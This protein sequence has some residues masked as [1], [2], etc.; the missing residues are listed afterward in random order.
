MPVGVL[1]VVQAP[2]PAVIDPSALRA[3][4]Y[5]APPHPPTTLA[6][7]GHGHGHGSPFGG[8]GIPVDIFEQI[9]SQGGFGGMGGGGFGGMGGG[10]PPRRRGG[11]GGF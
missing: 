7:R 6:G 5:H 2:F 8:G 1:S 3:T 11:F 10:P 4:P 9:F